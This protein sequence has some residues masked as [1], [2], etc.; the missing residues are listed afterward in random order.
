MAK[1]NV[2]F[3]FTCTVTTQRT[4]DSHPDAV[5]GLVLQSSSTQLQCQQR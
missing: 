3:Q 1:L 5:T 4:I 2:P